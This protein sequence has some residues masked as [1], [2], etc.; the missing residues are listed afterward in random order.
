MNFPSIPDDLYKL[1][2]IIG[3]GLII[4]SYISQQNE[5]QNYKNETIKYNSEVRT[6]NN[7]RQY[8]EDELD[9]IEDEADNYS[10]KYNIKNPVIVSDSGYVFNQTLRG[11]KNDVRVSDSVASLL[12]RFKIKKREIKIKDDQLK[13][14]SY[15]IDEI[16]ADFNETDN[17]TFW[18]SIIGT[19]L[20]SI[21][22]LRWVKSE[23]SKENVMQRQ[24]I[25]LPTISKCCQ[26]CGIIFNKSIKYGREEN[27][28]KNFNFCEM[29]YS[30]GTFNEPHL[31]KE[32][33]F[34]RILSKINNPKKKEISRIKKKIEGLERWVPEKY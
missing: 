20:F 32:E 11:S 33:M 24:N 34:N 18:L 7:E 27:G 16:K 8:L 12:S 1:L 2:V 21:G 17:F 15:V 14:Q 9:I 23:E 4:Y 31:K 5:Y 25:F 30:N 28:E 26:S 3:A 29:C 6:L 13:V 22:V 19:I 10:K